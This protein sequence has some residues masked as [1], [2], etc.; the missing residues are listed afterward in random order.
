MSN[1]KAK[2]KEGFY[3]WSLVMYGFKR[4]RGFYAGNLTHMMASACCVDPNY[5]F[6]TGC[7]TVFLG[8]KKHKN[9]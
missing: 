8:K 2:L 7:T 3:G 9:N 4:D 5:S 6:F 1:A